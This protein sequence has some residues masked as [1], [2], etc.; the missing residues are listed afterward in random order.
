MPP[1]IIHNSFINLPEDKNLQMLVLQNLCMWPILD[2]ALALVPEYLLTLS[3]KKPSGEFPPNS[4][5][6]NSVCS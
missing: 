1:I 3:T 4:Y 5:E 2:Q 6:L